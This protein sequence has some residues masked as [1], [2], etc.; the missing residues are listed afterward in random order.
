VI[1]TDSQEEKR[2][3]CGSLLSSGELGIW[4]NGVNVTRASLFKV[5][6]EH[7]IGNKM[8]LFEKNKLGRVE[9]DKRNIKHLLW[10]RREDL[11]LRGFRAPYLVSSEGMR[12]VLSPVY[13]YLPSLQCN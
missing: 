13:A 12:F 3:N 6:P 5:I 10:R 2:R 9:Y 4:L 8:F 11:S 7:K 1:R